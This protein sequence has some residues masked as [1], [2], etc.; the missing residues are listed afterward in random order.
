MKG[1]IASP[2]KLSCPSCGA[3]ILEMG[4]VENHPGWGI[5]KCDPCRLNLLKDPELSDFRKMTPDE[6]IYMLVG[7]IVG[8]LNAEQTRTRN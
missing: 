2:C 3:A 1:I 7:L 5:A 8:Q 4:T 6:N